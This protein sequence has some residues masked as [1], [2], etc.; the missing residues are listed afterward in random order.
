MGLGAGVHCEQFYFSN[1]TSVRAKFVASG[2]R[3]KIFDA[4][5]VFGAKKS[6][7]TGWFL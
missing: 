2:S 1:Y 5:N 3:C 6:A 4:V 7:V